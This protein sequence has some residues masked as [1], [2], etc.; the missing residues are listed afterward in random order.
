MQVR[1]KPNKQYLTQKE[2]AEYRGC[3]RSK[4][5]DAISSGKISTSI[6]EDGKRR[7]D[8]RKADEDWEANSDMSKSRMPVDE[9]HEKNGVPKYAESRAI[10]E[11]FNARIKKLEYEEKNGALVKIITIKAKLNQLAYSVKEQIRTLPQML[12][13]EFAAETDA[14]K[15]EL[16]LMKEIDRCLSDLQKLKTRI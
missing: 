1:I 14:R 15:I 16:R 11:A 4:V 13:A 9:N 5:I 2:Y 6:T 10:R 12:A 3:P 7:I 8:W